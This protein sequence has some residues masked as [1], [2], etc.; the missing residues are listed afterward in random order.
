MY[1]SI[2]E[3]I[4]LD[5]RCQYSDLLVKRLVERSAA[6]EVLKIM[7][8]YAKISWAGLQHETAEHK[9]RKQEFSL[10]DNCVPLT[11]PQPNSL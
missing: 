3:K 7:E 5:T 8:D 10:P 1:I 9:I 2:G 11:K 4:R 6:E